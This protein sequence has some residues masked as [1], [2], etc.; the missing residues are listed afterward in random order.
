MGRLRRTWLLAG[1]ALL[2]GGCTYWEPYPS[3]SVAPPLFRLPSSLRAAS[4]TGTP[5]LLLEPFVRADTLFGRVG[6][7]TVGLPLQQVR[8]LR[9]PRVDGLRTLGLIVG[10]SAVW[11]T[12]GLLGGG[13]E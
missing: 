7:D 12:A 8:E 6:G 3:P 13:L 11:I 10:V 1:M 5:L 9:R 4:D 2:S